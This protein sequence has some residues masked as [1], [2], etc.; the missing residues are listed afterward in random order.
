MSLTPPG[1]AQSVLSYLFCVSNVKE[2]I[3]LA[4]R[5]YHFKKPHQFCNVVS[6]FFWRQK[7]KFQKRH[8]SFVKVEYSG[9]Q[10]GFK[11]SSDVIC[12][13]GFRNLILKTQTIHHLMFLLMQDII[14][15]LRKGFETVA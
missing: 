8:H 11:S 10:F 13:V 7:L 1:L 14:I 2:I 6:E 5:L 15:F 12:L 3:S 9:Q 4:K